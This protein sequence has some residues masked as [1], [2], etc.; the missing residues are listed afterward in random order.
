MHT[1]AGI[2]DLH[3]R[4]YLSY[5]ALLNHL[6]TLPGGA[7]SEKLELL[8]W[9]TILKTLQHMADSEEFW[10]AWLQ[11][12]D[13]PTVAGHDIATLQQARERFATVAASTRAFL[14]SL[15]DTQLNAPLTLRYEGGSFDTTP[16]LAL[17]HMATHGFHHKGTIAS[18]CRLLGHAAPDT[19]LNVAP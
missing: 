17:L 9:Q 4:C 16:A 11:A 10:I 18:A 6:A 1:L 15:S 2:G 7:L 12:G 3:R 5:D 8:G 19:D 13:M 14:E